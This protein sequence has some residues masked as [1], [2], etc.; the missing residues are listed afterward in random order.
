[1]SR[2]RHITDGEAAGFSLIE[3]VLIIVIIGILATLAIR[4]SFEFLEDSKHQSTQA[5]LE[6]IA[7]AIAGDRSLLAGGKRTDFGYL[8]DIGS[9]PA[10]LADL[11]TNPGYGT[12]NGPY[13]QNAADNGYAADAWGTSYVYSAG[14]TI[15]STGSGSNITKQFGSAVSD[16]TGNT[17]RGTITDARG[18]PPGSIYRDSVTVSVVH[19]DGVGGVVSSSV[20]PAP[21]GAFTVGAIPAGNHTLRAVYVPLSDTVVEQISVAPGATVTVNLTFGVALW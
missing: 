21:S 2:N 11:V 7:R 6:A 18:I 4:N 10:S 17:V 13:L 16:F 3:L 9:L 20:L 12:W 8:G 19:P 15:Q 14:T 1:M 5:E